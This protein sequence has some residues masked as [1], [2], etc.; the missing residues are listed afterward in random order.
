M[1][2]PGR[3]GSSGKELRRGYGR[4]QVLVPILTRKKGFTYQKKKNVHICLCT[5]AYYFLGRFSIYDGHDSL[6]IK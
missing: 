1:F 6:E 3:L 5:Q 4:S 2:V